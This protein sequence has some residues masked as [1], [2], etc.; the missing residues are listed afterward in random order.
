M[1]VLA[2]G[3][4]CQ[5]NCPNRGCLET[6]VSGTA[7]AREARLAADA[8]PDSAL[9]RELAA[10][11]EITGATVTDLASKGDQMSLEVLRRIGF[12]LGTGLVSLTNIFNPESIVIGGGAAASGELFME[13]AREVLRERGLAPNKDIVEVVPAHFGAEAGMLGAAALAFVD[14]LGESLEGA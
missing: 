7:M 2:D 6:M 1:T 4:P 10:G 14:C 11:R 3:P 9:G 5:G 13:S 12:Y 8:E